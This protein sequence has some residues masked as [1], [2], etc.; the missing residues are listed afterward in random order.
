MLITKKRAIEAKLE[1]VGMH[2]CLDGN[3]IKKNKKE[4]ARIVRM[5]V[6]LGGEGAQM[7]FEGAGHVLFLALEDDYMWGFIVR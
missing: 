5:L 6:T 2:V 7:E 3:I 4:M 1:C